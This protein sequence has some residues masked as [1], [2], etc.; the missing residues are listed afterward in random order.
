M[1]S[2]ELSYYYGY[3]AE[4]FSF[5]RIPKLLFTDSRFAGI[6]TDAKLLYGIL[7]DRMSLSM[8][9]GWH[10]EQG[11]VYII[12]TLDDV[13]ETLGYKTEKA[14]KLFNELDT[15]K[16]VG[17]IERVRQ[18]QGRASLIY[19]KNFA[20]EKQTSERPK[21]RPRKNR[22]QDFGYRKRNNY[23]TFNMER[24]WRNIMAKKYSIIYADPPWRY[25]QKGVSGAAEKHYPTMSIEELCALPVA[26]ISASDSV[27]FL[28]TTFPQ[29]PSALQLI[30]A[31]GFSYKTVGFV[32]LKKNRKS[33]SWLCGMG[34]WTRGNA[35]I[36]LL[37]TKG[38]PKRKAAN[39]HQFIISPI[40]EHSRKPDEAR[41]KI[42]ALMG[43]LPR[44]ELFARQTSP[45]WD[46]WGN[47]VESTLLNFGP[48]H[49]SS[50]EEGCDMAKRNKAKVIRFTDEEWEHLNQEAIKAGVSKERFI[51]DAIAG[52]EL[53][54]KPPEELASL[55]KEL[56]AI[57]NNINQIARIANSK[58]EIAQQELAV[59]ECLVKQIWEKVLEL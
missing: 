58:H 28:W 38:H 10:D 4:Q 20:G 54:P 36:C 37:A 1:A 40:R 47:E 53:T 12:F 23:T 57:G 6:S 5:Y 34:F 56:N 9:N 45:G 39:V 30:K 3:E 31:W 13:A 27:L 46:V 50:G 19:V 35:E 42:V 15:K 44:I 52:I 7:L 8:K 49:I 26:E 41:E 21:S 48:T 29:L 33:D 24:V 16:G 2:V 32:W 55:I 25:N 51:R 14:I 43:D 22:G 59:I 17:L 11:R 18:G